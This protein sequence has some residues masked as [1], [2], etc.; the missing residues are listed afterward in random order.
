M[1][2][3]I[4]L[5]VPGGGLSSNTGRTPVCCG[6]GKRRDF[7][8]IKR[9]LAR[10]ELLRRIKRIVSPTYGRGY[11]GTES[12]IPRR[13]SKA[14]QS[15]KVIKASSAIDTGMMALPVVGNDP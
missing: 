3:R 15:A 10:R 2:G 9:T 8:S 1:Q 13:L 6:D 4:D 14:I 5:T 11:N 7:G 12:A